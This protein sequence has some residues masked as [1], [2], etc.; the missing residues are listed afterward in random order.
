MILLGDIMHTLFSETELKQLKAELE[1]GLFDINHFGHKKA[2]LKIQYLHDKISGYIASFPQSTESLSL[3]AG[4]KR[5]LNRPLH[6]HQ[7]GAG[8][9]MPQKALLDN[10]V[11]AERDK[12]ATVKQLLEDQID[13]LIE[14][15][16]EACSNDWAN[17][18]GSAELLQCCAQRQQ[19]SSYQRDLLY[20]RL[21]RVERQNH[22][23]D[24]AA[25]YEKIANAHWYR[26]AVEH[27]YQIGQKVRYYA[28]PSDTKEVLRDEHERRQ[29]DSLTALEA[30]T[31]I[32]YLLS[33]FLLSTP[34]SET[35]LDWASSYHQHLIAIQKEA[36][37]HRRHQMTEGDREKFSALCSAL[38]GLLCFVRNQD[39]Q[40]YFE[41]SIHHDADY[42]QAYLMFLV[43][44]HNKNPQSRLWTIYHA[45]IRA[46]YL[47]QP[48][49]FVDFLNEMHPEI[50]KNKN[51]EQILC[52]TACF[53]IADVSDFEHLKN[54]QQWF[55]STYLQSIRQ[56]IQHDDFGDALKR[57]SL[58]PATYRDSIDDNEL[59]TRLN[60]PR[61]PVIDASVLENDRPAVRV[62]K[63]VDATEKMTHLLTKI[64]NWLRTLQMAVD[65]KYVAV[66]PVIKKTPV[67]LND[68]ENFLD[69]TF[70][71][72]KDQ[73]KYPQ[74]F[75]LMVQM[76]Q[77]ITHP[78]SVSMKARLMD[79]E[80]QVKFQT[81]RHIRQNPDATSEQVDTALVACE[82]LCERYAH[83]KSTMAAILFERGLLTV[84]Q[85]PRKSKFELNLELTFIA[86]LT[87]VYIKAFSDLQV[88]QN[89]PSLAFDALLELGRLSQS[90]A[91]V[92]NANLEHAIYFFS[93]SFMIFPE[94]INEL[95]QINYN[96]ARE[97]FEKAQQINPS[98]IEL[99]WALAETY[100]DLEEIQS[101]LKLWTWLIEHE[102]G[103]K[104]QSARFHRAILMQ[105]LDQQYQ[106]SFDE[107]QM[108][109]E[110]DSAPPSPDKHQSYSQVAV[111]YYSG[112]AAQKLGRME[113]ALGC[114]QRALTIEECIPS[115][116]MGT[117]PLRIVFPLS[118]DSYKKTVE[119]VKTSPVVART[120]S[121]VLI[122]KD[123]YFV[124]HDF[125]LKTNKLEA[126]GTPVGMMLSLNQSGLLTYSGKI[127]ELGASCPQVYKEI[128]TQLAERVPSW[129]NVTQ[130]KI[131]KLIVAI[132][133]EL[134]ASQSLSQVEDLSGWLAQVKTLHESEVPEIEALKRSI[135]DSSVFLLRPGVQASPELFVS[136][137][138]ARAKSHILLTQMTYAFKTPSVDM[139]DNYTVH[140]NIYNLAI[141]D[142]Y[143][144]IEKQPNAIE[145]YAALAQIYQLLGYMFKAMVENSVALNEDA[146]ADRRQMFLA[147][148]KE[149]F[150][151]ARNALTQLLAI[152]PSHDAMRWCLAKVQER[153]EDFQSAKIHYQALVTTSKSFEAYWS[154]NFIDAILSPA[155]TAHLSMYDTLLDRLA[156]SQQAGL[157][158]DISRI[159][160]LIQAAAAAS[161]AKHNQKADVLYNEAEICFSK[162]RCY[163]GIIFLMLGVVLGDKS[164]DSLKSAIQL[165]INKAACY[166]DYAVIVQH[167]KDQ[168]TFYD[169]KDG[170]LSARGIALGNIR[171]M[172]SELGL[173]LSSDTT[174]SPISG[175]YPRLYRH[176]HRCVV[177][178]G[179]DHIDAWDKQWHTN[180]KKARE[181]VTMT[182]EK[183][184]KK[185]QV[186]RQVN[187]L[188]K[189][190]IE[191][192]VQRIQH[193]NDFLSLL[194]DSDGQLH[195]ERGVLHRTVSQRLNRMSAYK[196]PQTKCTTSAALSDFL[197]ALTKRPDSLAILNAVGAE[198]R[199][200]AQL[201]EIGIYGR[202]QD[203]L[204]YNQKAKETYETAA[205]LKPND[206]A[207]VWEIA[208]LQ[209]DLNEYT[210][211]KDNYQRVANS[212]SPRA[213]HAL[214]KVAEML[215]KMEQFIAAYQ[216]YQ[217]FDQKGLFLRQDSQSFCSKTRFYY[218]AAVVA[219]E[220]GFEEKALAFYD[221]ALNAHRLSPCHDFKGLFILLC[222]KEAPLDVCTKELESLGPSNTLFPCI[223][224]E[225]DNQFLFFEIQGSYRKNSIQ[226]DDM[227]GP[228]SQANIF[229]ADTKRSVV[230]R[231]VYPELIQ[232]ILKKLTKNERIKAWDNV[233]E[234]TIKEQIA[235]LQ[236]QRSALCF[237][238]TSTEENKAQMAQGSYR[239]SS[240]QLFFSS[241]ASLEHHEVLVGGDDSGVDQS[242]SDASTQQHRV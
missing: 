163:D 104:Q 128:R 24:K 206:M 29:Y 209:E 240:P 74:V 23:I 93:G 227:R 86:E 172:L 110:Q 179:Y 165:S 146:N 129:D 46:W 135:A 56:L 215:T 162:A 71:R 78:D 120:I 168:Y 170:I 186:M 231:R 64:E 47:S 6:V 174:I 184:L 207:L 100:T 72:Y 51:Q 222:A 95:R 88:A 214:L 171:Y 115:D 131:K 108:L 40:K 70:S 228:L 224:Q 3:Q 1:N 155:N 75:D 119:K 223:N 176:I 49:S 30:Y 150:T 123:G 77:L 45:G 195:F 32:L 20:W 220:A 89:E 130:A 62:E 81:I 21:A 18:T 126:K 212:D 84:L 82:W 33:E 61:T 14:R 153:L 90:L 12:A 166:N 154:I 94:Q 79:I 208:R 235:A 218:D 11:I 65:E 60:I 16:A 8:P 211:A 217:T 87:S 111:H 28:R 109:V 132:E 113:D 181:K 10:A 178:A 7:H 69:T 63:T 192:L 106:T 127:M 34:C 122:K 2:P 118:N 17:V 42:F 140:T 241:G 204:G 233:V 133:E 194:D 83:D 190:T 138:L 15:I 98:S 35:T 226:L 41:A 27:W 238:S 52:D 151:G 114:F 102:Q 54:N 36:P 43:K 19:H 213:R 66:S 22:Q 9:I 96:G 92:F 148:S 197:Y 188:D 180:I 193:Y 73:K 76:L 67:T 105:K 37:L 68:F 159:Q 134:A 158:P 182:P 142:L 26:A 58:L 59:L 57:W 202:Q 13:L 210:S 121:P 189:A 99:H 183:M 103:A 198:Y 201:L 225:A 25:Q 38:E 147:L 107:L 4:T 80:K 232:L 221:Q 203:I 152:D 141:D 160:L 136:L 112:V 177:A 125:D 167:S 139:S 234:T 175:Y 216:I 137:L 117:L 185:L 31:Q 149:N 173:I 145:A 157:L 53:A 196:D 44:Q 143:L 39:A 101:A 48:R 161:S 91:H 200:Q 169:N 230:L 219:A 5:H 199:A 239:S 97:Y 205:H 124:F 144:V 237:S 229:I 55:L 50:A 187:Q 156:T 116:D 85:I 236:T 242:L 191:Q 164:V